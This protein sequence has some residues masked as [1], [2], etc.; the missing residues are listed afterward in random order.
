MRTSAAV[1]RQ[2]LAERER[3]LDDLAQYPSRNFQQQLEVLDSAVF[4]YVAQR[5]GVVLTD[6]QGTA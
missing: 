4:F 5:K 3:V 2:L 6:A 1:V